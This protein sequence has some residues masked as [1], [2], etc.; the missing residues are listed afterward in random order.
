MILNWFY[1]VAKV[2][3]DSF[4]PEQMVQMAA[5]GNGKALEYFKGNEMGKLSSSGRPVDYSSNVAQRTGLKALG[6][7]AKQNNRIYII[8]YIYRKMILNIDIFV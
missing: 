3:L 4:T 8:I 5:G 2:E 7:S 6:P 1:E